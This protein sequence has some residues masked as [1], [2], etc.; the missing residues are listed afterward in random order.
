MFHRLL[1]LAIVKV[2]TPSERRSI[3][4]HGCLRV[5]RLVNGVYLSGAQGFIRERRMLRSNIHLEEYSNPIATVLDC[6]RSHWESRHSLRWQGPFAQGLGFESWRMVRS[7]NDL[8]FKD[9]R[10][11]IKH[12]QKCSRTL[13]LMNSSH[14]MWPLPSRNS[15]LC[16]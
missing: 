15:T 5:N 13:T 14:P 9:R 12:L 10:L 3:P 16:N 7:G 11:H 6:G 1:G 8:R 2:C 4:G